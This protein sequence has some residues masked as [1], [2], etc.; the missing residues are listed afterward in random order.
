MTKN[1]GGAA[2]KREK[3][4]SKS[5]N[6]KKKFAKRLSSP[7]ASKRVPYH[8]VLGFDPWPIG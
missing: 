3:G 2:H 7:T 4:S 6:L 5:Q 8:E 1:W